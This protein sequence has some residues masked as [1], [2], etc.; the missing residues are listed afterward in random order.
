MVDAA[1]CR[2]LPTMD[3]G[4]GS[5]GLWKGGDGMGVW[6]IVIF[7]WFRVWNPA[8]CV[9]MGVVL[10][11]YLASVSTLSEHGSMELFLR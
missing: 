4:V 2:S 11:T 10:L 5:D 8:A 7:V 6:C 9:H 1:P 3:L